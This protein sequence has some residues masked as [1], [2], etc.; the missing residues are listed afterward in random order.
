VPT[1]IANGTV[2]LTASDTNY[3]EADNDGV[4]TANVI[5][6]TVGAYP[7]YE[8]VT[9]SATVTDYVDYRIAYVAF[10]GNGTVTSVAASVP[11]FLS[12]A[13][14]PITAAG[15]LAI[16]LSGTALPV[17][18][19]GTGDTT[20]SGARTALGLA[21]GTDVQAYDADLGALAGLTSAA[22]KVPYFTGSGTASLLTRDID[23]T[24]TANSDTVL[25]TQKAIKTYVDAQFA[26]AGTGDVVGPASAVDDRVAFFDGTSG[27]LIKDSG[28]TLSGSNTGDQTSVSGNA[29]TATALQT[30]RTIGGVSFDGT[31]NIT[32]PFDVHA[33]YPGIPTA[34][35]ILVR[36]PVARAVG[37]VADFV[38]SYGKASAVATA[39][40][41]FDIQKNGSS[42]GTAT[43]ALGASTAT[44]ASSGGAAQS[45]AAGDVISIVAPGTPDATLADVGFVLAGTR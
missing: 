9:G 24:L 33:F 12:V 2:A 23:G 41:A 1:V 18:N 4:V 14:S 35:A 38:G 15:T 42:I 40:T 36:V 25:A 44:F 29:G 6:F 7:L 26:G 5:G 3:V 31:A 30:A 10:T 17:A 37:F 34:S 8:I 11:A 21:I 22:D 43:F 27:K 20:A 19:G 13:G 16:T 45:L 39:S 32:Q 28:L